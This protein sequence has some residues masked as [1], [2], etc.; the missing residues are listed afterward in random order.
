MLVEQMEG[1]PKSPFM[2]VRFR[3]TRLLH[4]RL[5][6]LLLDLLPL[7]FILHRRHF[8]SVSSTTERVPVP[9]FWSVMN[10]LHY[11]DSQSLFAI[12]IE[13]VFV[14]PWGPK[15]SIWFFICQ[16]TCFSLSAR[17]SSVGQVSLIFSCSL[18]SPSEVRKEY[19][20]TGGHEKPPGLLKQ[21]GI[22]A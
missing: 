8:S 20:S 22:V 17:H 11:F 14:E 1:K 4:C 2:R 6:V 18:H 10:S 5:L 7:R 3:N 12:T 21:P 15:F 9:F 16:V 19:V 13:I